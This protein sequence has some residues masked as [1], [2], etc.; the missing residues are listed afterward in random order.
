MESFDPVTQQGL[1]IT[2]LFWLE[3]AIS[4]VLLA[5]VFGVMVTALLRFR[6]RAGEEMDPP[7]VHGNRRL[8]VIWTMGPVVTLLI[9]FVLVVGTIRTVDAEEPDGQPL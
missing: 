9:I 3:I 7:Q 2:N 4:A 1:S 8:E 5:L 6:A